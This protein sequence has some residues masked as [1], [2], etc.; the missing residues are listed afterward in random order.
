MGVTSI[1][2][3]AAAAPY[4]WKKWRGSKKE[5]GENV[6]YEGIPY[7]PD[8]NGPRRPL[9]LNPTST[10]PTA[11]YHNSH[12]GATSDTEGGRLV[13]SS[14][15]RIRGESAARHL[16][17]VP[18]GEEDDED[19]SSEQNDEI[20]E[21]LEEQGFYRGSYSRLLLIYTL[22]PLTTLLVWISFAILPSVAYSTRH[23][24][25]TY[26]YLPYFPFP[27]P[28][29]LTAFAFWC[30]AYLSRPP[31]FTILSFASI[32]I[33]PDSTSSRL[34]TA[35]STF[36]HTV[37]SLILCI[38]SLAI[39]QIPLHHAHGHPTYC[40]P[41][42]VR[43]W[44]LALGWALA[45]GLT[46]VWQ[47]YGA[48]AAYKDVMVAV[49]AE[50]DRE[51][52]PIRTP[53]SG[54]G[55]APLRQS[56]E[57]PRSVPP[58]QGISSTKSSISTLQQRASD[59]AEEDAIQLELERDFEELMA[60][61]L[62]DELEELYGIP[63][64]K[65]PVFLSCMQRLNSVLFSLGIFLLASSAYLRSP[66]S[67]S[68]LLPSPPNIIPTLNGESEQNQTNKSLFITLPLLILIHFA[69][70]S[71]HTPL[72]LPHLGVH[73]VVY[74]GLLVALG[75]FFAGLGVWEALS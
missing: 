41:A 75:T 48:L 61:K 30:L 59:I 1:I 31:I 53:S 4:A 7:D 22:V 19:N 3:I 55:K 8:W 58:D 27:L 14:P 63:Y 71:L 9:L 49:N 45:E 35:L 2:Q 73:T 33:T 5:D 23:P 13:Y 47:G 60:V 26:P 56:P 18:E 43:V 32:F 65:I 25:T 46:A 28:E 70:S 20:E 11:G 29:L 39:L 24:S 36:L 37:L 50:D 51:A 38:A 17:Q 54:N 67:T 15:E 68:T 57:P 72:V 6:H 66:L 12:Y 69:L 10:S 52:S 42:F 34:P 21:E 74:A 16:Q 44:F 62:R 64:I 40:D